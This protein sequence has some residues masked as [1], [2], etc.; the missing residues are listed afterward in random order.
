[1]TFARIADLD[2]YFERAGEGVLL[3]VMNAHL[4]RTFVDRANAQS[5]QL[6]QSGHEPRRSR[7]SNQFPC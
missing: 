5:P 6:N 2:V 3:L 1:V 4:K 7:H